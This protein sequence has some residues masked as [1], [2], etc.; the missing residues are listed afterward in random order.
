MTRLAIGFLLTLPLLACDQVTLGIS[1][2]DAPAQLAQA[3][4]P[5]AYDCCMA[6]QLMSN[7]Q[8]GT[9]EPT[10]ETKTQ[11]AFEQQVA[12]IEASEQSGRSSYDG[13]KVQA[14]V[15][16]I[17]SAACAD[18][19]MTNHFSGIPAC[20]SFI[21]PKVAVGGACAN[22]Y[23]CIDGWC[24]KT[25][26]PDGSD[27]ACRALG[28]SGDPCANGAKCASTLVCDATT[29]TCGAPPTA[30]PAATSCF[31]SSAC[32]YAG[33][34]RGAASLLGLGL[35]AIAVASRTRARRRSRR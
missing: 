35:L 33:G 14:C 3:I 19:D 31:Y 27:G 15:T 32:S 28:Q 24:D 17:R 4:C 34:D 13:T 18:L 7:T 20:A 12:G 22:D 9:D 26:A 25:G 5:K 2:D 30:T 16:Y 11:A 21:A 1:P 8:A 6:S 23:E 29:M 10:C